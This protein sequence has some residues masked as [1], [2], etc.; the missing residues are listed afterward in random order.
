PYR[1][2]TGIG[3]RCSQ[4]LHLVHERMLIMHRVDQPD[5]NRLLSV[6]TLARKD[7][8]GGVAR[9]DRTYQALRASPARRDPKLDL[10]LR[11]DGIFGAVPDVTRQ[12]QLATASE[13]EP[14]YRRDHRLRKLL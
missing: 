8:L 5:P 14:V 11:K 10:G 2:G 12:R 4:C 9:T 6:D 3:D 1:A 7:H 13:C